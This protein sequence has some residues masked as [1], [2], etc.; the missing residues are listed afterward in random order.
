[1][2]KGN[3]IT[4][5]AD[6]LLS[7]LMMLQ[8]RGRMTARDL[9]AEL[10]VSERTIYRDVEAL[11]MAGVPIYAERGPGGGC[12]LLDGYRTTLTG[13]T[14]E[15]ARALFLLAIPA[16]LADL[17]M[18]EGLQQALLKLTASLPDTFRR[19]EARV[20]QCIHLDW[21]EWFRA[22]QPV[23]HL[24]ALQQAVWEDREVLLTIRLHFGVHATW[25]IAPYGLVSK[26]GGWYLVYGRGDSVRA[27]SLADVVDVTPLP[28]PFERPADFDLP[29]FWSAWCAAYEHNRPEYPVTVRV[30]P[31]LVPLL[32]L[33]FGGTIR[34]A[35]AGAP[36]DAAGWI[37]LALPFATFEEARTRLLGFGRAVE[38]LEP[39]ALRRSLIDHAQQIVAFYD[40]L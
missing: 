12:A 39:P 9:A 10:E 25:Q 21:S 30:A 35:I 6:R 4:M 14:E 23:P 40:S 27:V 22:S 11:S 13:L 17:G 8:A 18:S 34:Q 3:E 2:V 32:P 37:M 36:P 38:V 7:L 26:A 20:R 24:P 19:S 15:E 31:D 5:R 28:D 29:T 1:M 16:A 33:H